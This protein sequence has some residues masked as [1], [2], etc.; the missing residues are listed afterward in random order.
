MTRNKVLTSYRKL[1]DSDKRN[2]QCVTRFA[3]FQKLSSYQNRTM[4]CNL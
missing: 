2:V 3:D 1:Y 4:F